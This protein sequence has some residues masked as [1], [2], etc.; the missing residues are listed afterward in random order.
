[1]V[2][3]LVFSVLGYL[4]EKDHARKI[5]DLIIHRQKS[6]TTEKMPLQVGPDL[7]KVTGD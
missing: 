1:M 6:D 3:A 4:Y 2:G 7:E 5:P